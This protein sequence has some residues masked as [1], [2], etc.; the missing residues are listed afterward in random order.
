MAKYKNTITH[1]EER[2]MIRRLVEKFSRDETVVAL[3][4]SPTEYRIS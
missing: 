4:S 1:W 2:Q 3:N